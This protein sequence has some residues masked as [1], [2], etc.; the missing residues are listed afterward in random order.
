M[1]VACD[2]N[3]YED[4]FEVVVPEMEEIAATVDVD[5]EA[6]FNAF[7]DFLRG[8]QF[9]PKGNAS[10]ERGGDN[11]ADWVELIWFSNA[12]DTY[13][14]TNPEDLGNAC[15]DN[16]GAGVTNVYRET[17]SYRAASQEVHIQ[18]AETAGAVFPIPADLQALYTSAFADANSALYFA[19]LDGTTWTFREGALPTGTDFNFACSTAVIPGT[20]ITATHSGTALVADSSGNF[21]LSINEGDTNR[22]VV[23][24]GYQ[25]EGV[26]WFLVG[27]WSQVAS[28][29]VLDNL[30]VGET[31][32]RFR[33]VRSGST[34]IE[35]DVVITVTNPNGPDAS[36]FYQIT[37]AP[38][39]LRG[40]LATMRDGYASMAGWPGGTSLNYAGTTEQA[41]VDAIEA[42]I[43]DAQ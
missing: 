42:N 5:L 9:S 36:R 23:G 21:A 31:T 17:Y 25:P 2:K 41:V 8:A 27:R 14:Y 32:L 22:L 40:K 37:D 19:N 34:T 18:V 6:R 43:L 38:F 11:G 1:F 35:G 12:T 29:I 20:A 16:I 10:S 3:E 24:G 4:N 33:S 13:V 30:P 28:G 15:Y 26:E 7:N 39:P